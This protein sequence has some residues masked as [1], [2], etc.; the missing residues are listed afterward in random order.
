MIVTILAV[1]LAVPAAL[2]QAAF[3]APD[4]PNHDSVPVFTLQDAIARAEANDPNYA[5]SVANR[6]VAHLDRGISRSA[7]LPIVTYQNQYLYTQPNG[8]KNQ[9]GQGFA[10]QDAPRFIANNAIREYESQALVTETFSAANFSGLKRAGA[11]AAKATADAEVARRSLVVAVASAYYTLIAEESSV[12]VARRAEGE[13]QSFVD[14]TKKLEAGREVAHADVVKADLTLQQRQRD[15][16]DAQL[17]AEKARLDL[18][19][20]ILPDPRMPYRLAD[21]SMASPPLPSRTDSEAAAAKNNPQLKSAL[22]SLHMSRYEVFAARAAYLPTLSLNYTYGID[23][24]QFAVNGPSGVRNLGYSAYATLEIPVWDWF[25][26][27]DR[28]K[29]SE[30]RQ[31]VAQT[32][33][34]F[35]QKKLLADLDAYYSEAKTANDELASLNLSAKTAEES[36]R[37]TKLRYGAGEATALEVVDA[38][39]AATHAETATADGAV[40]YQVALANLQT[41]TGTI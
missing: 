25:A 21:S 9:A 3:T 37:L 16:A 29:Q 8:L 20:L 2:P 34:T 10:A 4:T 27:R 30:L 41:L 32:Q 38:Q 39:N 31:Q 23:A 40:R 18:G 17:A 15:L 14:L 24:P 6:G 7:L 12:L 22:E 33:L 11:S 5:A 13:A 1:L 19:M 28:I 35:T 36:L 26:T